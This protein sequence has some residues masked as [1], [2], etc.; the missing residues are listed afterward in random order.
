MQ[1]SLLVVLYAL[2][3]ECEKSMELAAS[4]ID[5]ASSD[6]VKIVGT[7]PLCQS[8]SPLGLG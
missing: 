8:Q 6:V 5:P 4:P 7:K 1:V 2:R 3:L